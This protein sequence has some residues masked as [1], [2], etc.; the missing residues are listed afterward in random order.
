MREMKV[1]LLAAA[2]IAGVVYMSLKIT[3]NQSGFGE[4]VTYRAIGRNAA[5]IFPKTPVR[6][7]GINAGRVLKVELSGS[8][9]LITFEVLEKVP[10][11]VNS[12]LRV[13]K[14]GLLGDRHLE[15][16]LGA[17]GARPEPLSLMPV[18]EDEELE[19]LIR[20]STEALR[21]VRM[22][23]KALR[24]IV[25]PES[26]EGM[27]PL[28]EVLEA[29]RVLVADAGQAARAVREGVEAN[30]DRL[31]RLVSGM[32]RVTENLLRQ[33]S[34]ERDGSAMAEMREVVANLGKAAGDLAS[35]AEDVR[36]GRGTMGKLLSEDE[37]ADEVRETLSGV[38]KLVG[39]ADEVRTE[40]EI[41]A[42]PTTGNG[43][44]GGANLLL[45][46]A[47]ERFYMLGL[48]A[49]DYGPVR[50]KHRTRTVDGV[51]STEV[52]TEKEKNSYLFNIQLGRKI[53]N[54]T[55][56][57]GV[58]RSSG[59][60][61]VDYDLRGLGA[62]MSLDVFDYRSGRWPNL[63]LASEVHFYNVFKGRV[64]LRDLAEEDRDVAF[65]LGVRFTDEDLKGL[66]GVLLVTGERHWLIRTSGDRRSSGGGSA[67]VERIL[68]PMSKKELLERISK[69]ELA[70]EDELCSGNGHWFRVKEKDLLDKYVH[71]DAPQ[72]FDPISDVESVLS[73]D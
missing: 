28:R 72:G 67:P 22:V 55:F 73:K 48:T 16:D 25:A 42:G 46:P 70:P 31:E 43:P 30:R 27:G 6:V 45:Y 39:K 3:S 66:L 52:F 2:A 65:G 5:G 9:A 57:G 23:T 68:G 13:Q 12:R 8:S 53:Q 41:F 7:A 21:D 60:L 40:L 36:G 26:G 37:I 14:V 24:E 32:E 61:G 56:R 34:P 1:G 62:K 50:E 51:T 33:S 59:G 71:G 4:H 20:H 35:L 54:W 10:L 17:P 38:R 47:P 15:I 58:F 49:S 19:G 63:R 44:E 29:A 64:A 69:G 18:D 11:T